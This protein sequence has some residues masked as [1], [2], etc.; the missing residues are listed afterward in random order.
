MR[1]LFI[2]PFIALLFASPNAKAQKVFAG[3]SFLSDM[4]L[5]GEKLTL[6]GGGLREKY[7]IDLYVAGLY[8]KA[9]TKDAGK[10]ING[11]E[12]MAIS[13]KLVSNSVTREKFTESVIEGFKNAS[14]GNATKEEINKFTG[15][16]TNAF[17]KGD[18]INL[19][20]TPGKGVAIEKNGT[21]LKVIAGLEFKKALFSIWLGKIPADASLKS[22]MLGN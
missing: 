10:I 22:G 4:Y 15:A 3:V 8:I 12:P 7:Y 18:Q 17:K 20:Y 11:D 5:G 21:Q 2:L 9:K 19:K 16:F 13:I 6:N 1:I 14:N